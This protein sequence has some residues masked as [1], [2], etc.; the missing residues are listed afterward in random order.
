MRR[1]DRARALGR[2]RDRV[3]NGVTVLELGSF[4]TAPYASLL[5]ADLGANVIKVEPPTGD[6]F[7]SFGTGKYSPN[8]VGYNR[9]KRSIVVDIK[10][11][12]GRKTLLDLVK[13]ADVL[14]EN[15][16]PGVMERSK[17]GFAT[18]RKV[19]P[20]LIYCSISGFNRGG[21]NSQRPAFDMIGQSLSGM[22]GLFLDPENPVVRGPTISDQ[23]AGFYACYGILG[24]LF[25]RQTT[26]TGRRVDVNMIEATMS[27]MP[28]VFASFTR[29][30][31]V[32]DSRTRA[33]YSQA[34]AFV[35]RDG[36]MIGLQLSSLEKFWIAFSTAIDRN[37]LQNDPRFS[38]RMQRIK[39]SETLNAL[40]ADVF[41]TR[42]RAEWMRL[43]ERA[44]VP[45]APVHRIDDVMT[46]PEVITN[47]SFYHV[48]HP[49]MGDVRCLHRPVLYDGRRAPGRYPPTLGEHTEEILSEF[50]PPKKSARTRV[51]TPRSPRQVK[52][53]TGRV[54]G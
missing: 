46:D 5:L 41:R 9:N 20:R 45:H 28:D 48:R 52:R 44:D 31:V 6:P 38:S 3:L 37:E 50:A 34:Y 51:R 32:M 27:F 2:A 10:D 8:F 39:N 21:A 4:I 30:K 15:F 7:R 14:I 23:L 13:S 19:N 16:R 49:E 35:C 22:L 33:A 47:K 17:L 12:A 29:D 43:L 42:P 25:A 24:A 53:R 1:S 36:R 11:A 40:L 26:G 18:L 54:R